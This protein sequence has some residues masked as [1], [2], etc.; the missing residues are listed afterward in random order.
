MI[1]YIF[2]FTLQKFAGSTLKALCKTVCWFPPAFWEEVTSAH[3]TDGKDETVRAQ[4]SSER[5]WN[6]STWVSS[7]S[8]SVPRHP[9]MCKYPSVRSHHECYP[10]YEHL[11]FHGQAYPIP[12]KKQKIFAY[13]ISYNTKRYFS[14]IV[15]K[16]MKNISKLIA[17]KNVPALSLLES[18][19]YLIL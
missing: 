8:P 19:S 15:P 18:I 17:W 3:P 9:Y 1:I 10:Q 7:C 4:R 11:F 5:G 13:K 14:D 2:I 6:I 12:I 16:Q